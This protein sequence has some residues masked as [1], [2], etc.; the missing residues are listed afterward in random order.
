MVHGGLRY[1]RQRHISLVRES[2]RER[3]VLLKI[4]PHLVRPFPFLLPIYGGGLEERVPGRPHRLRFAGRPARIERHRMLSRRE[5]LQQEP[6]LRRTAS[7]A[8]CVTSTA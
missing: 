5:V 6:A 3:G 7:R 2:L 4:A 8:P 1:L